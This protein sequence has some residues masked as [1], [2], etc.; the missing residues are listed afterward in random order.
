MGLSRILW[1]AKHL[2]KAGTPVG[3][4]VVISNR[5]KTSKSLVRTTFRYRSCP[6]T[7]HCLVGGDPSNAEGIY[8]KDGVVL[9]GC[10]LTKCR[11][12]SSPG[13]LK[14]NC[15]DVLPR[16]GFLPGEAVL[17]VHL[18]PLLDRTLWH[19]GLVGYSTC[20]VNRRAWVQIPAVPLR[21]V[22]WVVR[23]LS[24]VRFSVPTHLNSLDFYMQKSERLFITRLYTTS[25][26]TQY[27][28]VNCPLSSK[29][30]VFSK[31]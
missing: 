20:L 4:A 27:Y 9:V 16:W 10:K 2:M 29:S 17:I 6:N 18:C 24:W 7:G 11:V 21:S 25:K 23:N 31:S 8:T 22:V 19:C 1:S 30:I 14:V 15:P 28:K 26:T 3:A 13:I 5:P 12:K